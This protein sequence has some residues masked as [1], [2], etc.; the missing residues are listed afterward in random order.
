VSGLPLGQILVGDARERLAELPAASVDCII[1]SPPYW[2]LRDYGHADQ[3]GAEASVDAWVDTIVELCDQLARVLTPTGSLWLNLGD[4]F[5]RRPQD[6]APK[7]SLLLGPSRV[8]LQLL[9]HGWLL[10]NQV[11]WHKPNAMPS[12]V[13][14]RLTTTYEVVYFL[15]R[16]P[17]YYFDL[18][19]IRRPAKSKGRPLKRRPA[20]YPP[21]SAV[22]NLGNGQAPRVNLNRGLAGMKATGLNSHPL[23]K[24]PGDVWTVGTGR[25]RGAHFATFPLE[26]V[27]RPLLASCPERVC[28]ACS[29]P[30]Q[31]PKQPANK[32]HRP[33]PPLQAGCQCRALARRGIVLDPFIGAGTVALAAEQHSRDWLGIELNPVYAELARQRL[34]DWRT[35]TTQHQPSTT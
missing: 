11:I 19:A 8:A 13:I 2:A 23:G 24:N 9:N 21:R 14:D 35:T 28:T 18:D 27:R 16:Q 1:T 33:R 4:S 26:L 30:W 17:R 29:Q 12:S 7:K 34:A 10:R 6:G 22:P 15:T 25:Y 20:S 5:A 3:L 31:R 32:R